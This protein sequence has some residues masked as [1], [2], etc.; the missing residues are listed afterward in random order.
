[1]CVCLKKLF[2][3]KSVK[4]LITPKAL[5]ELA[6]FDCQ[7]STSADGCN[8]YRE[9]SFHEAVIKSTKTAFSSQA[10][11]LISERGDVSKNFLNAL[12]YYCNF[13]SPN[14]TFFTSFVNFVR[15][16]MKELSIFDYGELLPYVPVVKL[17]LQNVKI[18]EI[19]L[20]KDEQKIKLTLNS[21][22]LEVKLVKCRTRSFLLY[23]ITLNDDVVFKAVGKE[24]GEEEV[25]KG[26]TSNLLEN[27]FDDF[28]ESKCPA[29]VIS[30]LPVTSVNF[31]FTFLDSLVLVPITLSAE[32]EAIRNNLF[33]G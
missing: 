31:I 17:L 4:E 33:T 6:S 3:E 12:K 19:F 16:V 23:Q 27:T 28:I 29:E 30:K 11:A 1:M 9:K 24:D 2:T 8:V 15:P 25:V 26:N 13:C 21:N 10:S 18:D 7:S 32:L 5:I 22:L 14:S 20:E